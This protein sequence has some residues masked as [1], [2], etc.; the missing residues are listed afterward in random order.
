MKETTGDKTP[1]A[2]N[3]SP[4]RKILH[5]TKDGRGTFYQSLPDDP[6][7]NAGW[8]ISSHPGLAKSIRDSKNNSKGSPKKSPPKES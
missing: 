1:T 7:L 2:K 4:E 6:H 8:M 3:T 5:Q